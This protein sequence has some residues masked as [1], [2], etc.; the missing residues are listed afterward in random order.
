MYK[1]VLVFGIV[2]A[3]AS[4][5]SALITETFDT[6]LGKWTL[7]YNNHDGSN[8]FG[9]SN[10]NIAG[11]ASAGEAG[12]QVA[13]H[14]FAY[15]GDELAVP[16][17]DADTIIMRGVMNLNDDPGADGHHFLGFFDYHSGDPGHRDIKIGFDIVEPGDP[18]FRV[19]HI[20]ADNDH[21]ESIGEIPLNTPVAFDA[22]YE[23]GRFFGTWGPNTFDLNV[24]GFD[25]SANAIGMGSSHE[26]SR[27][28]AFQFH[29]DDMQYTPEPATVALLGL[30]SLVLIRKRR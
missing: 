16:L 26:G 22:T 20:I 5:A 27:D 14:D 12:G 25:G 6:D 9:W 18:G 7:E 11:G 2:L 13:R 21:Q 8:D 3:L 24:G 28:N 1:N 17:T 23:N 29:I 19:G 10:S 15:I 4:S 30:G